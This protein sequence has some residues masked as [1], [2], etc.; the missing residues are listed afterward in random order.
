MFW[1]RYPGYSL[2]TVALAALNMFH[3]GVFLAS[4]VTGLMSGVLWAVDKQQW[5][6][7]FLAIALAGVS[8]QVISRVAHLCGIRC[9]RLRKG[10]YQVRNPRT[11]KWL[12]WDQVLSF[13]KAAFS[14]VDPFALHAFYPGIRFALKKDPGAAHD[15]LTLAEDHFGPGMDPVRDRVFEDLLKKYPHQAVDV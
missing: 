1:N 11:G 10:H 5:A 2:L 9:L 8:Q 15:G 12:D 13:E 6:L 7:L 4:L 14:D 3:G